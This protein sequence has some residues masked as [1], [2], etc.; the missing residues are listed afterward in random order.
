MSSDAQRAILK[1]LEENVI[2]VDEAERLLKALNEGQQQKEE[3]HSHHRKH[4]HQCQINHHSFFHVAL[5]LLN[6]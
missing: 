1:M 6:N 2:N 4:H 3:P 5:C